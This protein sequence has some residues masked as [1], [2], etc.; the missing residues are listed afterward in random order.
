MI[1]FI[2]KIFKRAPSLSKV[3]KDPVRYEQEKKIAHSD[4]E[5]GRLSLAQ[6][7]ETHQEILY[8]LAEKDP[9]VAVRK[10]VAKNNATPVQAS[11]VLA[12][13]SSAEVRLALAE[14]L[15]RL[16]PDLS[17]DKHSQLYAFVAQ[18]MGTL[19]LD[20]VL[21]IRKA[22]STALKDSE[23]TPPKVASQLA[24]DI[25]R[26]V[27]EPIL[28]FCTALSDKDLLEI[29]KE[30]P[31]SWSVK[32][33]AGRKKVSGI[34][35]RA[36]IDTNNEPGGQTLLENKGAEIDLALLEHIIER[37]RDFPEWHGALA[38][39]KA[40]SSKM[41]KRLARYADKSVRKLLLEREDLDPEAIEE[42]SEIFKRRL[43]FAGDEGRLDED[44]MKRA[45]RLEKNGE[46]NADVVSD[47]LAMRDRAFLYAALARLANTTVPTVK[48]VFEMKAPKPIIAL[49]WRA[50]LSMRFA[51]KLQQEMG[52]IA[53]DELIYPK[54]GTD[55]PMDDEEMKWQLDFLGL[56]VK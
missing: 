25:E 43:D 28:M 13:D 52:H 48:K 7:S 22:L 32:A 34:I 16:L 44:P 53:P 40:L 39:R 46:L 24:R 9:S 14:R 26:E 23:Y 56:S 17:H 21:K 49:C 51:F 50:E 54:E 31:D 41:A 4:N 47:A 37:A 20:E 2:K 19:A 35:S 42:I 33:I 45:I 30:H 3:K 27:A 10:A 8:Y 6:S 38:S 29:L 15:V 55:Y 18:S 36:I 12:G 11:P 5:G 1:G